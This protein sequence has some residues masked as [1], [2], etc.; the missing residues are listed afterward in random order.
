MPHLLQLVPAPDDSWPCLTLLC[1]TQGCVD[2]Q[3]PDYTEIRTVWQ[4]VS[5][6]GNI[7]EFWQHS[8]EPNWGLEMIPWLWVSYATL[9][10]PWWRRFVYV[11]FKSRSSCV[12]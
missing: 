2:R 12:T 3:E 9:A 7:D 4:T 5:A 8:D 11:P 1:A 10:G 6:A